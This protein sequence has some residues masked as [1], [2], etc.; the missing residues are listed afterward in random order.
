MTVERLFQSETYMPERF[1]SN[2]AVTAIEYRIC[3]LSDGLWWDFTAL[4][5]QAAPAD[6]SGALT[7]DDS[8]LWIDSTGWV[9][10][11]ANSVYKVLFEITNPAETF[12]ASGPKIIVND[13]ARQPVNVIQVNSVT[14]K[15]N[16]SSIP[17]GPA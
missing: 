10:P 12:F 17:W 11:N 8:G 14:L 1:E 16:G 5:F 7:E 13:A 4:A 9:I 6:P 15:G 3:R 2:A